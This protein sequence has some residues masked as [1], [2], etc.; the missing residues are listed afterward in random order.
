MDELIFVR[1]NDLIDTIG[2][3]AE[4]IVDIAAKAEEIRVKEEEEANVSFAQ[5]CKNIAD[6]YSSFFLPLTVRSKNILKSKAFVL[7]L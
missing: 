7:F 6:I 4:E 3:E 1:L 5:N 2:E